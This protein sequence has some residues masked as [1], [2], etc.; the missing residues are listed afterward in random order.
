M[1][2]LT[3]DICAV[4]DQSLKAI[5]EILMALRSAFTTMRLNFAHIK[6]VIPSKSS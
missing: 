1:L 3:E 6:F 2:V 4:T 5:E